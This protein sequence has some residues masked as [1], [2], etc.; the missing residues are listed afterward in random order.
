MRVS[1]KPTHGLCLPLDAVA[2]N[3]V[4]AFRLDK[5]EGHITVEERVMS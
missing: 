3:V 5:R 4:E 1:A 2:T